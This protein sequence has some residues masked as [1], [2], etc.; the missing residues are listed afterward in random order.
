MFN[1]SEFAGHVNFGPAGRARGPLLFCHLEA[2]A[3]ELFV[4]Y[5][6]VTERLVSRRND[7]DHGL[8]GVVAFLAGGRRIE[9]RNIGEVAV[10]RSLL[11]FS[12]FAWRGTE[13]AALIGMRG[14]SE[15]RAVI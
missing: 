13:F 10:L 9:K 1:S 6:G 15:Q 12:C 2:E 8:H 5:D 14:G 4:V 7:L 11:N 3:R